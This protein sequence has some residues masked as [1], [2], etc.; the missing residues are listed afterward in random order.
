VAFNESLANFVGGQAAIEFFRSQQKEC[1]GEGKNCT[2]ADDRVS[3]AERE[4]AFQLEFGDTVASLVEALEKLYGSE[5]LSS[6]EKIARR[7]GVFQEQVRP[8]RTQ[9]PKATALQRVNNAE[10]I[11]YKLYLTNL[12]LFEKLYTQSKGS[13][14]LFFEKIRGVQRSVE[15]DES[16]DPFD[17]LKKI[18]G[19][20][21]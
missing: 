17:V 13:W 3:A 1:R 7:E 11:Q 21:S 4:L 15:G 20:E 5:S 8:F 14:S 19:E 18:V 9:Y 12:R 6:E 10:I 2:E 16:R